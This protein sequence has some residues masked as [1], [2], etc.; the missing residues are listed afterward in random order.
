[1]ISSRYA[2]PVCVL[3]L[4]ALVPTIIHSYVGIVVDDGRTIASVPTMLAGY[5]STPS[6]RNA[7][8]GRRRFNSDDWFERKY[9]GAGDEVTLTVVR[10]YDL[11]PLYHHP[12]LAIAYV[13]GHSF[14]PE[15]IRRFAGHDDVPVHVV[16]SYSPDSAAVLYAL[17]YDGRFIDNPIAFQLRTSG[18]LLFSGRRAMTLFFARDQTA[19]SDRDLPTAGVTR[20]L[21]AAMN[22]FGGQQQQVTRTT[23][24]SR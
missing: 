16:R 9:A 22:A 15:R 18:E 23:T 20:V 10:S 5:S 3:A 4:M 2:V 7:T 6:D 8:W 24:G 1:V 12:E 14:E 13:D 11:T 21:F 19:P 17:E